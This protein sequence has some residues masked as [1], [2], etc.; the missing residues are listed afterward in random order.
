MGMQAIQGVS[1][2]M[3]AGL[4]CLQGVNNR[5]KSCWNGAC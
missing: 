5:A 4:D 3:D 1:E 2:G